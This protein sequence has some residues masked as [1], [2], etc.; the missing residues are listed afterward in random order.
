VIEPRAV[1]IEQQARLQPSEV[2]RPRPLWSV[3]TVRGRPATTSTRG[4]RWVTAVRGT[5]GKTG[6]VTTEPVAWECARTRHRW[7]RTRFVGRIWLSVGVVCLV[8]FV[9][10][11]A[12]LADR[13]DELVAIGIRTTGT[14][15]EDPPPALRCG[16]VPVDVRFEVAGASQ[17]H[18]LYVGGCGGDGLSR[19]DTVTVYYDRS[20]PS[21]FVA[22]ESENEEPLAILAASVGLVG[23]VFL[24]SSW[25]V[26]ARGLHR[27]RQ[28]LGSSQWTEHQVDIDHAPER[29]VRGRL[30][31]SPLDIDSPLKLLT[32]SQS[33]ATLDTT[34][35]SLLIARRGD[36]WVVGDLEGRILLR[37][38]KA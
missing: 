31:V 5:P 10:Y 36:C 2:A 20:D 1:D 15:L 26:R 18:T 33:F 24:V 25:A 32:Q 23:G 29:W 12:Q 38:R 6:R 13:R 4:R 22:D 16:Q 34:T 11:A 27:I 28:T 19:G 14:V 37:A 30:F 9:I 3:V 35:K 7:S 17:V 8:G 21:N